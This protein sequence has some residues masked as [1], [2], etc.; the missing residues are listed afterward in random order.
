VLIAKIILNHCLAL[1]SAEEAT[2]ITLTA[3]SKTSE[4]QAEKVWIIIFIFFGFYWFLGVDFFLNY[5]FLDK[6]PPFT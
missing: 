1:R 2:N 5:V 3:M 4:N 6:S